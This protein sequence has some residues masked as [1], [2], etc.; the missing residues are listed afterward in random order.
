MTL[1]QAVVEMAFRMAEARVELR[2]AATAAAFHTA[3][4][5]YQRRALALTR[6]VSAM[7]PADPLTLP[8]PNRPRAAGAEWRNRPATRPPRAHTP[9]QE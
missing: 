6:L 1:A 3:A 9:R 4:L 5:S 8:G 2:T 7:G